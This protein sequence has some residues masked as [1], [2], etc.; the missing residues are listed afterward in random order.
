METSGV[1]F[2]QP[3]KKEAW[4]ASAKFSDPDGNVYWLMGAPTEFVRKAADNR[5]PTAP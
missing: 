4:G 2:P 5:A 1:Q 3:L